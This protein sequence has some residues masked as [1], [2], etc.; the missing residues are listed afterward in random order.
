G[1]TTTATFSDEYH[2]LS[3]DQNVL[4]VHGDSVVLRGIPF[5]SAMCPIATAPGQ[6]PV[7]K[8]LRLKQSSE[9]RLEPVPASVGMALLAS[10]CP[11][12]NFQPDLIDRLLYNCEQ[13]VRR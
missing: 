9:D 13:I 2:V 11:F 10:Q 7:A 8:I 3:D 12:V 6:A 5:R 1:K 4:M